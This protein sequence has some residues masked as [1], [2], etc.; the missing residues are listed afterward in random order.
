MTTQPRLITPGADFYTY[1]HKSFRVRLFQAAAQAGATDWTD[2][3][4]ATAMC[5]TATGLFRDLRDHAEHEATFWHPLIARVNADAVRSI[6]TEH[7]TQD[8]QLCQ[9][10]SLLLAA[11]DGD[12]DAGREF[13]RA[14]NA[15][16][17]DFLLHLAEEE[18]GNPLLWAAY[19]DEDLGGQLMA[20]KL[21]IPLDESLRYLESMLPAL[22]PQDRAA[23]FEDLMHA[24]EPVVA[25]VKA[26][27]FRVLG[28][29]AWPGREAVA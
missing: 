26:L 27:T 11:N 25:A 24:P 7:A 3:T 12:I 13:Y 6:E 17:G 10:E 28:P 16:L 20:F 21:S 14:L 5:L 9:L 19:A 22:N 2:T 18:Q 15:F 29:E 4:E 8:H 1:I 23:I